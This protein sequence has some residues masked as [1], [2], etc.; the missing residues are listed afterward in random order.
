[1]EL[2]N[3]VE[4]GTPENPEPWKTID[5]SL[6]VACVND[7]NRCYE[8]TEDMEKNI[9]KLISKEEHTLVDFRPAKEN[10]Q[11]SID[12]YLKIITDRI[13]LDL[14]ATLHDLFTQKW[15]ADPSAPVV[16]ASEPLEL[17]LTCIQ[18]YLSDELEP[19]MN[20][21]YVRRLGGTIANRLTY[22]YI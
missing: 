10:L 5:F 2:R 3:E 21:Y 11:S 14:D 7:L 20:S 15:L 13:F 1:M 4:N 22:K 18:E 17:V 12:F 9:L 8:M 6:L 19:C 16:E